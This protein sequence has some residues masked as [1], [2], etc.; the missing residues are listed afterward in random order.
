MRV[1]CVMSF[2]TFCLAQVQ[3]QWFEQVAHMIQRLSKFLKLEPD[4]LE[5]LQRLW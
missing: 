3:I 4:G 2:V 5:N 1:A